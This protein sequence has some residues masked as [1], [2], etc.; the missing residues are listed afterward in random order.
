MATYY[1][2]H[3]EERLAYQKHYDERNKSDRAIYQYNY[4][5]D[6]QAKIVE[7]SKS[8]N[9][10]HKAERAAYQKAYRASRRL[11]MREGA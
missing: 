2:Q 5:T 8:Y 7:K 4:Y 11:L 10:T 1:A 3:R 9:A 6:N